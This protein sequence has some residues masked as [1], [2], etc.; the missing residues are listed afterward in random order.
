MYLN[1]MKSF[2]L[3]TT[4]NNTL[5]LIILKNKETPSGQK[6]N[7]VVKFLSF[8][9]MACLEF[10]LS[11]AYFIKG[12]MAQIKFYPLLFFFLPLGHKRQEK[13]GGGGNNLL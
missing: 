7:F 10:G 8:S 11:E 12:R 1:K 5:H 4:L 13:G 2:I 9:T 3:L 6:Q